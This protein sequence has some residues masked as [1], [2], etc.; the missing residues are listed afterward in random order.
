MRRLRFR[1]VVVQGKEMP[2]L[3]PE[4][5]SSFWKGW[6]IST[7]P[8]DSRSCGGTQDLLTASL[9]QSTLC[10]LFTYLWTIC[11]MTWWQVGYLLV[12]GALQMGWRGLQQHCLPLWLGYAPN[13]LHS[14]MEELVKSVPPF[15][16]IIWE[17]KYYLDLDLQLVI[18]LEQ[19]FFHTQK[20]AP[21]SQIHGILEEFLVS[22]SQSPPWIFWINKYIVY[23]MQSFSVSL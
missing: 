23:S 14:T 1:E 3:E 13:S 17:P 6:D 5:R 22:G 7:V 21:F 8:W 19:I 15:K 2:D 11:L 4:S 18:N 10:C 9:F 12:G 16:L 20:H